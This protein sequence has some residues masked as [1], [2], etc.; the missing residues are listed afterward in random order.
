MIDFDVVQA[1]LAGSRIAVVGA[2][3][4]KRNFGRTIVHELHE[5]EYDVVPVN[6]NATTVDG[7]TAY[8][9]LASVSGEIDGVIVMVNRDKAADVVSDC[10]SRGVKRVWL[11]KGLGAPG[12]VSEDALEL[13]EL[14]GVEVVAGACPLMFLEPVGWFHRLHRGARRLNGSLTAASK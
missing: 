11:F 13:A 9:D 12:A 3:D 4:D 1:F 2:S 7:L 8:A 6:P 10:V 14:H 5:R